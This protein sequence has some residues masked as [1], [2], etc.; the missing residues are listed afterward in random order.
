MSLSEGFLILNIV[1]SLII[2]SHTDL[3]LL[4]FRPLC[5]PKY[6]NEDD[7]VA[8]CMMGWI[9]KLR[10]LRIGMYTLDKLSISRLNFSPRITWRDKESWYDQCPWPWLAHCFVLLF[11][12]NIHK[13]SYPTLHRC[14]N[15]II[16][17]ISKF[18]APFPS[19]T[20]ILLT[21]KEHTSNGSPIRSVE[22]KERTS[23]SGKR[24]SK[25]I[26][27]EEIW[28]QANL[29]TY[30]IFM[31]IHLPELQTWRS[32]ACGLFFKNMERIS[33]S[34]KKIH[35]KEETRS[36][37][38]KS[39]SRTYSYDTHNFLWIFLWKDKSHF[40]RMLKRR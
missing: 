5:L 4:Q 13:S 3:G 9:L 19:L 32:D 17:F 11:L 15:F 33:N 18:Q 30:Q 37:Q 27:K 23:Q 1:F 34:S 6:L 12:K 8:S 10:Y 38:N 14:W 35:P 24:K 36:S 20:L 39:C 2:K 22:R 29:L 31:R 26:E 21:F 40:V 16:C 7:E 28:R 25:R